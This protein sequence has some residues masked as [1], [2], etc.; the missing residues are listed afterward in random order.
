MLDCAVCLKLARPCLRHTPRPARVW[1]VETIALV[2]G[3]CGECSAPMVPCLRGKRCIN[4]ECG[5][6]APTRE[7]RIV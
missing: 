1:P 4:T 7:K 6:I 2:G 3:R 5:A